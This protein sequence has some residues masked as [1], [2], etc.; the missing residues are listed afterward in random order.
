MYD[1]RYRRFEV[2][3]VPRWSFPQVKAPYLMKGH[4]TKDATILGSVLGFPT[5]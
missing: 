4:L 3:E 1:E 2:L 5:F